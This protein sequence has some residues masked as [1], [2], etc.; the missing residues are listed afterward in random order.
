MKRKLLRKIRHTKNITLQRAA[1]ELG[2]G[3]RYLSEIEL[4]KKDPSLKLACKM[5]KFFRIPVCT[6]LKRDGEDD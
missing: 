4:G 5:E 3:Y 1:E 2:I 6:L